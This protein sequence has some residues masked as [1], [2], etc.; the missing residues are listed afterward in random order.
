MKRNEDS[1]RS[2][3]DISSR[4]NCTLLVSHEKEGKGTGDLFEE[5]AQNFPNLVIEMTLQIQESQFQQG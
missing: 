2:I 3:W 5:L 1:L 4:T